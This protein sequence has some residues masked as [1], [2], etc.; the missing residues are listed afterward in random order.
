[1]LLKGT[2][3]PN[4]SLFDEIKNGF[5]ELATSN[6]HANLSFSLETTEQNPLSETYTYGL[7]NVT[8]KINVLEFGSLSFTR[9]IGL[10]LG[11]ELAADSDFTFGASFSV[12]NNSMIT[13]SVNDLGTPNVTGF[14]K[15]IFQASPFSSTISNI[16]LTLFMKAFATIGVAVAIAG[17]EID[18]LS[19]DATI[20]LPYLGLEV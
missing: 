11:V 19:A 20:D 14:D 16:S 13:F 7:G 9:G 5:V 2:L 1:M 15:S 8:S 12:P 10:S 4:S 3:S 6:L 18:H 17:E